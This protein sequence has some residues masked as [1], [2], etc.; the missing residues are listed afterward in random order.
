MQKG[1]GLDEVE[2]V[3]SAAFPANDETTLSMKPGPEALGEPTSVVATEGTTV[4]SLAHRAVLPMRRDHL[5]AL[6]R[7][8][9]I[10]LVTFVHLVA[11][12]LLGLGIDHVEVEGQLDQR[13]L[14]VI[15]EVRRDRERQSVAIHD[16]HDSHASS[17]LGRPNVVAAGLG[18]GGRR[19]DEAFR[20]IKLSRL[21]RHVRQLAE[22]ITLHIV[23]T[24]LLKTTM[25]RLVV[26]MALR[27]HV[28]LK[29]RVQDPQRVLEDLS[30]RN[31]FAPWRI[32]RVALFRKMLADEIS[33]FIGESQ[34]HAS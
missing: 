24:P 27:K 25:H 8:S 14:V 1:S 2:E 15:G 23:V 32:V 34:C 7:Q 30:G 13:D 31:R 33:L 19:I 3:L 4:P 5:H 12:E 29:A 10:K 6:V 18:R 16:S 9:G 20:W 28:P 17:A 21:A 26:R 11:D 22:G